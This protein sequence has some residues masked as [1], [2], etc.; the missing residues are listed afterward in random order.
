MHIKI[1]KSNILVICL[2]LGYACN[3]NQSVLEEVKIGVNTQERIDSIQASTPRMA[4][5][6][7][8]VYNYTSQVLAGQVNELAENDFSFIESQMYKSYASELNDLWIKSAQRRNEIKTWTSS[9]LIEANGDGGTLFYPFSGADFVHVDLFF[10][11]YNNIIMFAIEPKGKFPDLIKLNDE[12]KLVSYLTALK[13]SLKD[14]LMLSFFRTIAMEKDFQSELDGNIPVL[15]YFLKITGHD[16]HYVEPVSISETGEL[17]VEAELTSDYNQGFRYYFKKPE[18]KSIRT[19]VYFTMNLQNTRYQLSNNDELK[20]LND[21]P[22]L[23]E[24]LLKQNITTTYTKSAS[25][26][27]HRQSFSLIRDFI[28][29]NSKFIL[30]DDSGIPLRYFKPEIWDITYYG[31]Y[32]KPIDLFNDRHQKDLKMAYNN[33]INSVKKL[34]FGIGYQYRV[35]TSNMQ[36]TSRK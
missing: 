27:L 35:G 32:N 4:D 16:V 12:N 21:N 24:F 1:F 8:S 19:L 13:K 9:E 34:P 3:D 5:P 14:I 22:K 2:M 23:I 33:P 28:L 11:D 36:L 17:V 15:L 25:Y 20:G 18:D 29:E 31:T 30:Q 7:D 10:P 6:Y 26:L